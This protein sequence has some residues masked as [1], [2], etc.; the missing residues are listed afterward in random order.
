MPE[1]YGS[2]EF[3]ESL[4]FPD[5]KVGLMMQQLH[6]GLGRHGS[7]GD[8]VMENQFKRM[9]EGKPGEKPLDPMPFSIDGDNYFYSP[10]PHMREGFVVDEAMFVAR[11]EDS[12][13]LQVSHDNSDPAQIKD[14][15]VLKAAGQTYE[16]DAALGRIPSVFPEFVLPVPVEA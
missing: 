14:E 15:A 11:G 6:E 8:A 3:R 9:G 12:V 16:G 10:T 2:P 5:T 4:K 1:P 13:L 7:F